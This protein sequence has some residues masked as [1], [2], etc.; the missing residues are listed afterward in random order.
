MPGF[1]VPKKFSSMVHQCKFCLWLFTVK[2]QG[3]LASEVEKIA[4]LGHLWNTE[5]IQIHAIQIHFR[6][7]RFEVFSFF[8]STFIFLNIS[9]IYCQCR[10]YWRA[11][12][13]SALWQQSSDT[14]HDIRYVVLQEGLSLGAD[15]I[16]SFKTAGKWYN[17]KSRLS[18]IRHLKE[19]LLLLTV[20]WQVDSKMSE[21]FNGKRRERVFHQY[22]LDP[23]FF[24][25]LLLL[26]STKEICRRRE[27]PAP[28]LAP[29]D[30]CFSS[31]ELSGPSRGRISF[32]SGKEKCSFTYLLLSVQMWN[33]HIL[34][35]S[36]EFCTL[37]NSKQTLSNLY[38]SRLKPVGEQGLCRTLE[39]SRHL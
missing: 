4:H 10:T 29:H 2:L 9:C 18:L 27:E 38:R 32:R 7:H 31:H 37:N 5:Y 26:D 6:H 28:G 24:R 33:W 25:Q 21:G 35:Q 14:Q 23:S 3:G 39:N 22:L 30:S 15:Q 17:P 19:G 13:P 34:P 20:K 8:W 12:F 11:T 16:I 1:Q 36:S